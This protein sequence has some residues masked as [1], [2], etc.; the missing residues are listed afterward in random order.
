MSVGV[1]VSYKKNCF[2]IYLRIGRL[3]SEF[4]G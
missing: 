3:P 2:D 4:F 1:L